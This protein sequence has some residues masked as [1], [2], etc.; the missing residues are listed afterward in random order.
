MPSEARLAIAS[1]LRRRRLAMDLTQKGLSERSGVTLG[2]LRKFE[3]T[4]SISLEG[5]LKLMLVVG[6]IEETVNATAVPETDFTSID[7]VIAGRRRPIRKRGSR[8]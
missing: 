7:D 5:L 2:T 6:G 3:R 1:N 8:S 4:G